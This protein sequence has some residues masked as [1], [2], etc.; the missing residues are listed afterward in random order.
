MEYNFTQRQNILPIG[1]EGGIED[2]NLAR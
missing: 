1:G 2:G